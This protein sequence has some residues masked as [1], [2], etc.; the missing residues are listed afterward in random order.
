MQAHK[1]AFAMRVLDDLVQ[2]IARLSVIAWRHPIQPLS[3]LLELMP[4]LRMIGILP[5]ESRG[6]TMT[7]TLSKEEHDDLKNKLELPAKIVAKLRE[8]RRD[9]MSISRWEQLAAEGI[10]LMLRARATCY[11]PATTSQIAS[12]GPSSEELPS[13]VST[14]QFPDLGLEHVLTS[15]RTF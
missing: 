5:H 11:V 1:P 7:G 14:N 6:L 9:N 4:K 2:H 3:P 12:F 8:Y 15:T 10:Q 13:W